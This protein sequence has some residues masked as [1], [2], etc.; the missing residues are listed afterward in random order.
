[1]LHTFW[2]NFLV[3]P[4]HNAL[5]FFVGIIPGGDVGVAVILLT[6][7]V[8]FILSPLSKKASKSQ[9]V[10]RLLSPELEKIKENIP[11]KT[12]QAQATFALYKKA[13]VNPFS[14]CLIAVIQLP[15]LVALFQVFKKQLTFT[16]AS[17]YPF[18][19][20]PSTV[21]LYFL[22]FL[23]LSTKSILLAVIVAVVQYIQTSFLLPKTNKSVD[24]KKSFQSDLAD[25][26][27]TQMKYVLPVVV[28]FAAYA[29]GVALGL[30][31]LTSS[32]FT[33]GQEWYIKKHFK[34][35]I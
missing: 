19:H 4:L 17:L 34:P 30:Y 6:L 26:M 10:L 20:T 28:G 2:Y 29:G 22:G 7:V 9:I 18:I 35:T 14:G 15:I 23:S 11:D 25:S 3:E 33:I 27:T 12:A 32:L 8:K 31:L 21:S 5:A 13:G 24:T 1:M 16:S